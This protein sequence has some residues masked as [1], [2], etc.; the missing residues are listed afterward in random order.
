M[1]PALVAVK[2]SRESLHKQADCIL[3]SVESKRSK[4]S[5]QMI[6]FI[7]CLLLSRQ[8]FVPAGTFSG[9]VAAFLD[10]LK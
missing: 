7:V 5:T 10:E 4:R 2:I 1:G 6:Q 9:S 3:N 8:A